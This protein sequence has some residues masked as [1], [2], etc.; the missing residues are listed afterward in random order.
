MVRKNGAPLVNRFFFIQ[1]EALVRYRGAL[2]LLFTLL[3]LTACL[4]LSI[5][6]VARKDGTVT[7]HIHLR[8]V[9]Q[10]L[11]NAIRESAAG[12][13]SFPI[14]QKKT[15]VKRLTVLDGFLQ[16][17]SNKLENGIRTLDLEVQLK[18]PSDVDRLNLLDIMK[19]QFQKNENTW[20]WTFG[21]VP[22]ATALGGMDQTSLLQQIE[23]LSTLLKGFK[24]DIQLEAPEIIQTN[25]VFSNKTTANYTI[26]F[27]SQIASMTSEARLI[28]YELLLQPKFMKIGGLPIPL[29]PKKEGKT[30]KAKTKKAL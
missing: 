21:D 11:Q 17:Y 14:F 25:L 6:G 28:Y 27:D 15:L 24:L 26:D 9:D 2:F 1:R 16:T 13:N 5:H 12:V 4:D 7:I 8:A 30:P 22:L 20:L 19:L 10:V 23:L 29:S 3:P 18:H